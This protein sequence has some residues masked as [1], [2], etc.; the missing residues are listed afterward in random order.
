MKIII[1]GDPIPAGRPRFDGR[2]CYQPA[3]TVEY[4]REIEMAARLAMRGQAPMTGALSAVIKLYRKYM[5]TSRRFGDVDNHLKALFD[6]MNQIVFADD[7]QIVTCA[8]EKHSDAQNPRAEI[9][10]SE[11]ASEN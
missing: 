5:P 10:L 4:R 2:R 6:G 7:S 8:V 3:R 1:E 11:V 9:F